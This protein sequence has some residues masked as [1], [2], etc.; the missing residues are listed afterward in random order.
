MGLQHS[1]YAACCC[2]PT[3]TQLC[4]C[5]TSPQ[6]LRR[7]SHWQLR[8]RLREPTTPV[9]ILLVSTLHCRSVQSHTSMTLCFVVQSCTVQSCTPGSAKVTRHVTGRSTGWP[10]S[11]AQIYSTCTYRIHTESRV[12]TRYKKPRQKTEAQPR[13]CRGFL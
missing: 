4:M 1:G 7:D 13:F 11:F 12:F 2:V 3:G 6:L 8:V 10:F 9:E 5:Y